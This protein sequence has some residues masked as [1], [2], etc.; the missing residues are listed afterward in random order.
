M[1]RSGELND[2][3]EPVAKCCRLSVK[4][5][6][7]LAEHFREIEQ[8]TRQNLVGPLFTISALRPGRPTGVHFRVSRRTRA[9]P[10]DRAD[11]LRRPFGTAIRSSSSRRRSTAE[12]K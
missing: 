6:R 9:E 7:K 5:I 8:A 11:R 3:V 12:S 2:Q 10:I 4:R 1:S